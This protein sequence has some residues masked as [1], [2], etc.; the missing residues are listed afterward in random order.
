MKRPVCAK[1]QRGFRF[2]PAFAGPVPGLCLS[3]P[4]RRK[5]AAAAA[6]RERGGQRAMARVDLMCNN[7]RCWLCRLGLFGFAGLGALIL[8]AAHNIGVRRNQGAVFCSL[9]A[10]LPPVPSSPSQ[11]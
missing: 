1:P 9:T 8:T 2:S 11:P 5:L 4:C 3:R 7:C 10:F 6:F